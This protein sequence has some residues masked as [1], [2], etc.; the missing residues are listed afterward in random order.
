ME[1]ELLLTISTSSDVDINEFYNV[2]QSIPTPAIDKYNSYD[3]K[4]L[5][6][7]HQIER[8]SLQDNAYQE[9]LWLDSFSNYLNEIEIA[10]DSHHC[11]DNYRTEEEIIKLVNFSF[12]F[13]PENKD[14]VEILNE[15]LRVIQ[16]LVKPF[17]LVSYQF[18]QRM[19]IEKPNWEE[20]HNSIQKINKKLSNLRL[21]S[22]QEDN[23]YD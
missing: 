20:L 10:D 19:E 11:P 18:I 12:T 23:Y 6:Q 2:H 9:R 8:S 21:T 1:Y 22:N 5:A 13:D 4:Q 16:R 17:T 14:L 15:V 3:E 7:L